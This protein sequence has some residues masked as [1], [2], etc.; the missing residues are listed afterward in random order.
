MRR[1]AAQNL[2]PAEGCHIQLVPRQIH[3]EGGGGCV[4]QGQARAIIGIAVAVGMRTPEVV[5]FQ[6]KHTSLS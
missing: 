2:L 4:T 1:L 6:V 5:P 3:G